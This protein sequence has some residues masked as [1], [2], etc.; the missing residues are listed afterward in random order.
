[1]T[2][3]IRN[4]LVEKKKYKWMHYDDCQIKKKEI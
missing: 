2:E 1:M 3:E 4:C